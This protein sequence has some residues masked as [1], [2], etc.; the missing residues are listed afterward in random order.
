M[1]AQFTVDARGLKCPVN[2]ARAKTALEALPARA[3]LEVLVDDPRS[4][5]DL[6]AAAEAEGHVVLAV[7]RAGGHIRILIEK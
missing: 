5:R 2:W 1:T 3:C 4:E 7:E 6:P